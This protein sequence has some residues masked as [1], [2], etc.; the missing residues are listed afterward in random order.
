MYKELYTYLTY[1][2][3]ILYLIDIALYNIKSFANYIEL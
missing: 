1:Q 2:L 3:Y